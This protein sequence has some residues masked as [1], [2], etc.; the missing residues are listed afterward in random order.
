MGSYRDRVE[1]DVEL[2][3][4]PRPAVAL[5]AVGARRELCLLE[6][7]GRAPPMVARVESG[8]A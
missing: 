5:A 7:Q 1:C 2:T 6:A 8:M 3:A 4:P